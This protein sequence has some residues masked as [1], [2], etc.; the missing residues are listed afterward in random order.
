MDTNRVSLD[1]RMT[2]GPMLFQEGC[3]IVAPLAGSFL[4]GG[5]LDG[6]QDSKRKMQTWM[7]S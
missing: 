7:I 1:A 2:L 5:I 3:M 4:D 6:I